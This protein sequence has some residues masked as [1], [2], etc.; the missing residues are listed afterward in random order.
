VKA[1]LIGS[2]LAAVVAFVASRIGRWRGSRDEEPML[3]EPDTD[4]TD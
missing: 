4:W 3:P 1:V 2:A